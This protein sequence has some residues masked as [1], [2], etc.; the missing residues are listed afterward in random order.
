MEYGESSDLWRKELRAQS[1]RQDHDFGAVG[2]ELQAN[3]RQELPSGGSLETVTLGFSGHLGEAGGFVF[4]AG[5]C[6]LPLSGALALCLS[7]PERDQVA[8]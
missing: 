3:L 5:V 2:W 4:L 6:C 1:Q 8:S 7:I